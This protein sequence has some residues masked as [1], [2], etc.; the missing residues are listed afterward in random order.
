[1][2]KT[3][4]F[5][6]RPVILNGEAVGRCC[7]GEP[8]NRRIAALLPPLVGIGT[9][10]EPDQGD[11]HRRGREVSPR[12]RTGFAR[13]G[14][15][16]HSGIG[17]VPVLSLSRASCRAGFERDS[18]RRRYQAWS[19]SGRGREG[20]PGSW[21]CSLRVVELGTPQPLHFT[22]Q[23]GAWGSDEQGMQTA[24]CST[25]DSALAEHKPQCVS[26]ICTVTGG[27]GFPP[28]SQ[29][30]HPCDRPQFCQFARALPSTTIQ[31]QQLQTSS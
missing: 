27:E 7:G 17:A 12:G 31:N 1:M 28:A 18:C 14:G 20:G 15:R 6:V 16:D 19:L 3:T 26:S 9:A 23:G 4:Y 10:L 29:R 13:I 2:E 5:C 11:L 22:S 21:S 24:L 8:S 30:R 25:S